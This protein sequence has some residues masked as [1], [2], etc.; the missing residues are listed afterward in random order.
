MKKPPTW[1]LALIGLF[2]LTILVYAIFGTS[3]KNPNFQP[4]EEF[5]LT[6]WIS[7]HIAGVDMSINK[8]VFYLFL[9]GGLTCFAMIYIA[10]RM[11]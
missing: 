8:A 4:Q 2:A 7:L 5:R 11:Q 3:G 6:P 1:L 9:A 10:R